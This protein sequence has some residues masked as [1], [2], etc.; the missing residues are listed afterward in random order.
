MQCSMTAA[1]AHLA[2]CTVVHCP[3]QP[4]HFIEG[5]MEDGCQACVHHDTHR[6]SSAHVDYAQNAVSKYADVVSKH[7][8][9]A[10]E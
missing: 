2:R 1:M 7:A 9:H 8:K 5:D 4:A 6:Y 10:G 3:A